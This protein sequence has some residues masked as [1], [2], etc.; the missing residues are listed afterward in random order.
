[1]I[2][3]VHQ[4]QQLM[5]VFELKSQDEQNLMSITPNGKLGWDNPPMETSQC[6]RVIYIPSKPVIT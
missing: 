3:S 4:S 5:L 6:L 1:G 2:Q